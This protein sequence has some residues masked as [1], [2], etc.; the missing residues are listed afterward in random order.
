MLIEQLHDFGEYLREHNARTTHYSYV[1]R[2]RT[3]LRSLPTDDQFTEHHVRAY[4]S[5]MA[6][7]LRPST[8]CI[9][10]CAINKFAIY[11]VDQGLIPAN[12]AEKVKPPKPDSPRRETPNKT[13]VTALMDACERI[14][15]P[16]RAALARA[17]IF[18]LVMSGL[19]RAEVLALRIPD[20]DISD[21]AIYVRHG[22]GDKART[23]RPPVACITALSDYL[24]VR[25]T[26]RTNH[27][28]LLKQGSYMADQGLRILLRDLFSIAG[29]PMSRALLPHGLRH[30]F[31]TRL[32]ENGVSLEEIRDILG[33]SDLNTTILYLHRPTERAREIAELM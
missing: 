14:R 12:P 25:P 5:H 4:I 17:V 29:M 22:K 6:D 7:T 26:C 28:F 11:L 32:R 1:S 33:H 9:M 20:I 8:C 30:A 13:E 23:V 10:L 27:V 2:V 16:Y 31:A 19:R 18:T 15:H 24:S 3:Y 21:G